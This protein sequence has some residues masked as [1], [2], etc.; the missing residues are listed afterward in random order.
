MTSSQHLYYRAGSMKA[1]PPLKAEQ[2]HTSPHP[3]C[4][5]IPNFKSGPLLTYT[6]SHTNKNI[7]KTFSIHGG[8]NINAVCILSVDIS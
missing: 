6:S 3:P 1:P 8:S 4:Y 2:H 5:V 7:K